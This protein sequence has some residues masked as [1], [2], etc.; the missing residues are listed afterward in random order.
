MQPEVVS[1]D[2]CRGYSS[3][4]CSVWRTSLYPH[5]PMAV[6]ISRTAYYDVYLYM[7]QIHICIVVTCNYRPAKC[8]QNTPEF[9]R[10]IGFFLFRLLWSFHTIFWTK[11]CKEGVDFLYLF[12]QSI[13]LNLQII[14]L[15]K[16]WLC[17]KR[18]P[19]CKVAARGDFAACH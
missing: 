8:L 12:G 9:F 11:H 6:P 14:G 7:T 18:S 13:Q 1:K 19:S 4:A 15:L 16:A 17:E 2:W 3:L 5:S 10:G